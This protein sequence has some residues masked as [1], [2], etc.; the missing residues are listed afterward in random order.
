MPGVYNQYHI[1]NTGDPSSD[2]TGPWNGEVWDLKLYNEFHHDHGFFPYKSVYDNALST[3]IADLWIRKLG[4]TCFETFF[5]LT[6]DN[7]DEHC[8]LVD[9]KNRTGANRTSMNVQLRT[10]NQF[11]VSVRNVNGNVDSDTT[12]FQN[13]NIAN[14]TSIPGYAM[15]RW[16]HLVVRWNHD[17][18]S[19]DEFGLEVLIGSMATTIAGDDD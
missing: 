6:A 1:G 18:G 19:A 5:Y 13:I 4:I 7:N 12:Q 14:F 17:E 9:F 16:Y 3:D 8:F 10:N 15:N 11:R 2:A